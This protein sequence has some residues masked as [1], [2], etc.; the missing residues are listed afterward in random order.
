MDFDFDILD[1]V[2]GLDLRGDGLA[3]QGLHKSQHLCLCCKAA[4]TDL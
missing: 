4:T 1:G 3:L 2:T